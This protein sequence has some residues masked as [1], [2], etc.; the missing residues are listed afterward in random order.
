MCLLH[1]LGRVT[2]CRCGWNSFSSASHLSARVGRDVAAGA[3]CMQSSPAVSHGVAGCR[4]QSLSQGGTILRRALCRRLREKEAMEE[5]HA[6]RGGPPRSRLT[7]PEQL[8]C[9]NV[10]LTP[11]Q[12]HVKA[13]LGGFFFWDYRIRLKAALFVGAQ[14]QEASAA[15]SSENSETTARRKWL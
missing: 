8:H 13:I 15:S 6:L 9:A 7:L 4:C 3:G 1:T 10:N 11:R 14:K 2:R 5:V 12:V